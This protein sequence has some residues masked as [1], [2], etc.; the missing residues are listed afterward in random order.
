LGAASAS[1]LS[2]TLPL[3]S[4]SWRQWRHWGGE[5]DP[6]EGDTRTKNCGQIYK[7]IVDKRGRVDDTLQGVTPEQK[8]VWANL[9]KIV[10]KRGRGGKKGA[11]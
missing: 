7:K 5:A 4:S 10:D 11:G 8:N 2:Q 1:A 3:A 6:L 9:Q